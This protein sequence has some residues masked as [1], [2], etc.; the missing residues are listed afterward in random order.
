[1]SWKK[2]NLPFN[3]SEILSNLFVESVVWVQDIYIFV[4]VCFVRDTKCIRFLGN[5]YVATHP[6]RYTVTLD[7][8]RPTGH[9]DGV[10]SFNVHAFNSENLKGDQR[11]R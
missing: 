7:K 1:M 4:Y 3:F 11:S 6:R 5:C 10:G 2:E 9:K 8:L